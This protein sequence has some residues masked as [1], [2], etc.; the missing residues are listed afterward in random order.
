MSYPKENQNFDETEINQGIDNPKSFSIEAAFV[1]ELCCGTA[2][3]TA[4]VKRAGFRDSFGVD[5][6][7]PV[8]CKAAILCLDMTVHD[9][10]RL[11]LSWLDNPKC[12]GVMIAPPCGTASASR[13]IRLEH[14]PGGGPKEL[15]TYEMPDG[16]YPLSPQYRLR[17]EQAN[18]LYCFLQEVVE[19]SVA[20]S[21]P[22][23][24][25]NPLN[26]MY[27]LTRWWTSLKCSSDMLY[28]QHQA[29]AYGSR[30]PKKTMLAC[31]RTAFLEIN[32]MCPG[33]H[34]HL[35]WGLTGGKWATSLEVHYPPG[36]CRALARGF[37]RCAM[38]DG[39]CMP[40]ASISEIRM[41]SRDFLQVVRVMM[42]EPTKAPKLPP[43]VPE[44][45]CIV[46][47]RGIAKFLPMSQIRSRLEDQFHILHEHV[48]CSDQSM[49]VLPEGSQLLHH[50]RKGTTHDE[51]H[52]VCEQSWGIPWGKVEFIKQVLLAGHPRDRRGFIPKALKVAVEANVNLSPEQIALKRAEWFAKWT[53]RMHE[54]KADED[55]L[56]SSAPENL[57]SVVN[58]KRILLFKEILHDIQYEDSDVWKLLAEGVPLEGDIP[59]SHI[60]PEKFRPATITPDGLRSIAPVVNQ[61][62]LSQVK[63]SEDG[64]M[65]MDMWLKTKEELEK[66]WISDFVCPDDVPQDFPLAR[67]F[68]IKQKGK[69]RLI[70]DFS[71]CMTNATTTSHEKVSLD[72]VDVVCSSMLYYFDLCKAQGKR[73]DMR[74]KTYDLKSAYKQVGIKSSS[75]P[76]SFVSVY[77][78]EHRKPMVFQSFAMPFGACQ[79]VP[80]FLRL[81]R[82]VWHI[83]CVCLYI[84]NSN[85]FDD[86]IV[87][88]EDSL[89]RSTTLA[90][91]CLLDMLGWA[92][93]KEG[94]K[95]TQFAKQA[96]ALG[97]T[98]DFTESANYIL[99][100]RNTQSRKTELINEISGILEEKR[101]GKA[102]ALQLRGR[103]GFAENHIFGRAAK[104]SMHTLVEHAYFSGGDLLSNEVESA[105]RSLKD[106][107][108]F[109][110]D[111]NVCALSC[112]TFVIRTDASYEFGKAG[113]GGILVGPTG[114]LIEYFSYYLSPE[115]LEDLGAHEKETI[116]HECEMIA[117]SAAFI[118]WESKVLGAQVIFC[119]DNDGSR[120]NLLGGFG[121]SNVS[122]VI[123]RSFV[124]AEMRSR[125][126]AWLARV[127]SP[128]NLSDLPSRGECEYLNQRGCVRVDIDL[129]PILKG[130]NF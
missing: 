78:P 12:R 48:Q 95:A 127:P 42:H 34:E 63:P 74:V 7:R 56:K 41:D 33:D 54:L 71:V 11:I 129:K 62:V 22:V 19:K 17:V 26:S 101:L 76:F 66:G 16:V 52:D 115:E 72:T 81:S 109:G 114:R 6:V 23:V 30:R 94:P 108:E 112:L 124:E 3:F 88:S 46:N 5:H 45:K 53:S 126:H 86:Y 91:E 47:L 120:Y 103:L 107:I 119:L 44:H 35:P 113:L 87:V 85:F 84:M 105:L 36:L 32:A 49:L 116:I 50:V 89:C 90:F 98:L 25:E 106:M 97:I 61:V 68:A 122:N 43:L 39:I 67:R 57:R 82:A 21:I 80:G 73:P 100:I 20:K 69:V 10:Q 8:H 29:C 123:V 64:Q 1:I 28:V 13:R 70:D 104:Q 14:L 27:W 130:R 65:D 117:V 110:A 121:K 18:K 9:S 75:K 96:D 60:F 51:Q 31:N 55:K 111:R 83:A 93:D 99:K 4:A 37:L 92:Y 79:S 2:G 40:P 24:V 102:K 58:S 125:A 38:E 59:K 118:R 128:S 15:R 77:S